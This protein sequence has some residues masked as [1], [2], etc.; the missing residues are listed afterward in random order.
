MH[1]TAK[2]NNKVSTERIKLLVL[3]IKLLS[4]IPPKQTFDTLVFTQH[5]D[6][7]SSL[8]EQQAQTIY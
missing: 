4:C 6:S 5:H 3:Q 7:V 8:W 1:K 2:P